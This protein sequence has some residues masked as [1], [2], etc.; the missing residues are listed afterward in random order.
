MAQKL[1]HILAWN[2]RR[3][4]NDNVKHSNV[5]QLSLL[6]EILLYVH[7]NLNSKAILRRFKKLTFNLF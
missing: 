7:L 1:I 2:S 3:N 5:I 4:L 6:C